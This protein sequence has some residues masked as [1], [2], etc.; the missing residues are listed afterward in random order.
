MDPFWD[1]NERSWMEDTQTRARM[2][3]GLPEKKT[4]LKKKNTFPGPRPAS[5]ALDG[6]NRSREEIVAIQWEQGLPRC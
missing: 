3:L 6:N 2:L 5:N 4:E 1:L